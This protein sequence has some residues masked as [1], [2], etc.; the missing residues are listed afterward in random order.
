MH[1]APDDAAAARAF[2]RA[3]EQARDLRRA[4][5]VW[6]RLARAGDLD[7]WD[8]VERRPSGLRHPP[9]SQ[10]FAT[11]EA[12]MAPLRT[13]SGLVFAG[14]VLQAL[15][16]LE[17]ETRWEVSLSSRAV[18][19]VACGP[20]VAH[21]D[22]PLGTRAILFR[23]LTTGDQAARTPFEN[24]PS[25]VRMTITTCAAADRVVATLN[26]YGQPRESLVFEAGER[27]GGVLRALDREEPLQGAAADLLLVTGP[28]GELRATPTEGGE[29]RWRRSVEVLAADARGALV[30]R[31][32]S[33]GEGELAELDLRDGEL[34]WRRD[35]LS[36]Q[37]LATAQAWLSVGTHVRALSRADGHEVWRARGSFAG[38][39]LL[40]TA[41][42]DD[43]LYLATD[44]SSRRTVTALDLQSGE[45]L[46][47]RSLSPRTL[48]GPVGLAPVEGGLIVSVQDR[49]RTRVE[50][51]G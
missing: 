19:P 24:D 33:H 42:A 12:N 18:V 43:V 1:A 31:P 36:G 17:L 8:A 48:T 46:F 5:G 49:A 13:W 28:N 10:A 6:G 41:L 22:G 16:P 21:E 45:E 4:W 35:N 32:Y 11:L 47:T 26:D 40:A 30:T 7:A 51:L 39:R 3:C 29:S 44:A 23:D 37:W 25:I 38:Q 50:R 34:R 9:Q 20:W 27:P 2:A 14:R 15:D